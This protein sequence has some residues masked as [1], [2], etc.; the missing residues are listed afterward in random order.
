MVFSTVVLCRY[1]S[2]VLWGITHFVFSDE[3]CSLCALQGKMQKRNQYSL[4]LDYVQQAL[5][6]S[7]ATHTLQT[8]FVAFYAAVIP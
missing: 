7:S 8:K 5:L 2:F 6:S 4:H 1:S 3:G